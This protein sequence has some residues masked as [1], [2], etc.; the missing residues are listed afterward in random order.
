MLTNEG[1]K[2]NNNH[3]CNNKHNN[4]N[5]NLYSI[6]KP[7]RLPPTGIG[8]CNSMVACARS[9]VSGMAACVT[10]W[11]RRRGLPTRAPSPERLAGRLEVDCP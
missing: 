11:S 4:T 9:M 5:N 3:K 6:R 8:V 10:P 2:K 7:D 1:N